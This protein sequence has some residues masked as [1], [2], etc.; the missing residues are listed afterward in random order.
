M[1]SPPATPTADAGRQKRRK[2]DHTLYML[3]PH[4]QPPPRKAK[5]ALFTGAGLWDHLDLRT[6]HAERI[7]VLINLETVL[8]I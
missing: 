5:K 6:R 1:F 2:S 4:T 3:W 8:W 7:G